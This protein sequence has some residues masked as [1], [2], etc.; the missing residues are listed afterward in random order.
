MNLEPPSQLLDE[1][2]ASQRDLVMNWWNALSSTQRD[3][4]KTLADSPECSIFAMQAD[5]PEATSAVDLFSDDWESTWEQDWES[6]WREYLTEHPD[7]RAVTL[8]FM[9]LMVRYGD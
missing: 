9:C 7:V 5:D 3:A 1:L 4:L 2:D 8:D 6:D